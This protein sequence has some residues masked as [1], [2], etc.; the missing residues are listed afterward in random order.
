MP[1]RRPI[2]PG[3]RGPHSAADFLPARLSLR[4]LAHAARGCTGCDL[5]KRA[6]QTVFGEGGR[7]AQAVLVG[8]QPGDREDREGHPFVGPAGRLLERALRDA[9]IAREAVY[10]TNAVKHFKWIARGKRR[11]H[12]RPREG[13]IDACSPWLVAE[14]EVVRPRVVVCLGSTAARAVFGRTVRIKDYRGRFARGAVADCVLVTIHPSAIL[15]LIDPA[16][17]QAE[18]AR[19]VRDLVSVRERL[20]DERR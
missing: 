20:A 10:I 14:I 4:A 9:G 5:Y 2:E 19:F 12:Q 13:E 6:T 7:D 3:G 11:L 8:E 15:R 16:G 1:A 18:Y 17:R